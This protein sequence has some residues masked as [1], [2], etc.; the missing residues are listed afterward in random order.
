MHIH[1]R[2]EGIVQ[3]LDRVEKL[4]EVKESQQ[5]ARRNL[6]FNFVLL[7][8]TFMAGLPSAQQIVTI[9]ISWHIFKFN[10]VI[11]VQILYILIVLLVIIS[12]I[13]QL[14]PTFNK[15]LIVPFD[16]SH[17]ALKKHFTWPRRVYFT[18]ARKQISNSNSQKE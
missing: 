14:L 16:Q 9:I 1:D 7:L 2:Y 6:F 4:I 18:S 13:W 17:I 15:K 8:L 12:I 3:K 11:A 10:T 5:L